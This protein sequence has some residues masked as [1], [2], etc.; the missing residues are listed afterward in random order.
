MLLRHPLPVLKIALLLSFWNLRQA[1]DS[2]AAGG[3]ARKLG[4]TSFTYGAVSERTV[5]VL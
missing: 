2:D 5:I 3:R 1:C 4:S